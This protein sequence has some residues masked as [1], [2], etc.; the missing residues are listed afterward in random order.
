M[1]VV[2]GEVA[3]LDGRFPGQDV[4]EIYRECEQRARKLCYE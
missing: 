2:D 4:D 1:T 3:M